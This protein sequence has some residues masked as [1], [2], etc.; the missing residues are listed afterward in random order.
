M[1][2]V[3]LIRCVL[4]LLSIGLAAVPAAYGA[5]QAAGSGHGDSAHSESGHSHLAAFLG[6]GE[7]DI[8]GHQ[9]SAKAIGIVYECG[10]GE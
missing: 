8:E 2:D 9:E 4:V 5:E 3:V 7:E 6:A 1:I 10:I